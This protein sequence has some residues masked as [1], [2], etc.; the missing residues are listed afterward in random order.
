MPFK[1]SLLFLL[2]G[3]GFIFAEAPPRPKLVPVASSSNG[4]LL[5]TASDGLLYLFNA[6]AEVVEQAKVNQ[7]KVTLLA[8]RP[9][10]KQIAV[11]YGSPGQKGVVQLYELPKLQLTKTLELH[12]DLIQGLAYSPDGKRLATG[13]YDRLIKIVDVA[14]G[15]TDATLKD[16]SDAVYTLAWKPDG[17][18]LASVSADRTVKVWEP[19]TGKR[20]FTL[21]EATDWL[22]AVAWSSDGKQIAAGGVDKSIRWWAIEKDEG[23]LLKSTFA[24]ELGIVHLS[25]TNTLL[26]S[27]GEEGVIKSWAHS[28][29][30]QN[31]KFTG[32]AAITGFALQPGKENR[33]IA[34]LISRLDGVV[35]RLDATSGQ[36]LHQLLPEKFPIV[37]LPAGTTRQQSPTVKTPATLTGQIA[38]AGAISYY[39]FTLSPNEELGIA[40]QPSSTKL[41]PM[42]ELLDNRGQLLTQSSNGSLGFRSP[43]SQ[44]ITLA[45]RDKE[46][47]GGESYSY[48]LHAGPVPVL[49]SHFPLEVQGSVE[50]SVHVEGVHLQGVQAIKVKPDARTDDYQISLP[51]PIAGMKLKL[52]EL[53][54][55][56]RN[57][58]R[59]TNNS[60]AIN[61]PGTGQGQF[62]QA[63]EHHRWQFSASKGKS[64]V[65]EVHA[66]RLGSDLDSVIEILDCQGK[67][68]ERARLS[69]KAKTY[70]TLRDRDA[71][72]PGLRLENWAGFGQNDY[73]Y[74]GTELLRLRDMPKGPDEDCKFWTRSGKRL[75]Y[76]GTTPRAVPLGGSIYQ[77]DLHPPGTQLPNNGYPNF[78]LYYRND[79]GG[80]GK[81]KDSFLL[82]DPPADGK[83]TVQISDAERRGGVNFGYA[84]TVREPK[85][86][87]TVDFSPKEPK[88][89]TN[90]ASPITVT[91]V[92]HDGYAG[93]I[94]ISLQNLDN[95]LQAASARIEA[96]EETT[97]I[98][99]EATP[100][101]KGELKPFTLIAEASIGGTKQKLEVPG[102]SP[103]LIP[104][105]DIVTMVESPV[106]QLQPGGSTQI[107]IRIERR[108]GFKGRIPLEV[109]GLPYGVQV[110]DVGLNGIL[111]TERDMVRTFTLKAEP[112]VK[113]GQ[114]P[115]VVVA[116]REGKGTEHGSPTIMLHIDNSVK[117]SGK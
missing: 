44:T 37:Q 57:Q 108:N 63:D 67:P 24:H 103:K 105:G 6:E 41:E 62:L 82:F 27:L 117:I 52:P 31:N 23:K 17:T 58:S 65:V 61:I 89:T 94:N 99:L 34:L 51:W 115:L 20:L 93:P 79:D 36:P 38:R 45:I 66:A 5:A 22:Y 32:K 12:K 15:R 70:I 110:T 68:V 106:V 40:V 53:K 30:T 90:G 10:G 88:L 35:E 26:Y 39:Q 84:L 43:T 13:S 102:Q 101:A 107:T 91:A 86:G 3:C 83:Y 81:G 29:L 54:V 111:I 71:S 11:A 7:S 59:L 14:N 56:Q 33:P 96:E 77:V 21:S 48:R 80:Q 55:T 87:F 109:R 75:G 64:L 97:V 18:R 98:A 116:K 42:L 46:Y 100:V 92:R 113:P 9:D 49:I 1:M 50:T 8:F 78:I 28:S 19:A 4:E 72:D 73:L 2:F 74:I 16:H 60:G 114:V 95:S 25:F 47:R 104:P 69:T 76:L 112:W 85:P